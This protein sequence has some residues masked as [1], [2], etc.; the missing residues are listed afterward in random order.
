MLILL[1]TWRVPT[2][3][4]ARINRHYYHTFA[5]FRCS[6]CTQT[7]VFGSVSAG[8]QAISCGCRRGNPSHG[9]TVGGGSHSLLNIWR[10]MRQRC[11]SRSCEAYKWYG[12]RGITICRAWRWDFLR[13]FQWGITHGWQQ[14]LTIERVNNNGNY[15]PRNCRF[16]PRGRQARNRRSNKLNEALVLEAR[17][18][19]ASGERNSDL[20]R[21]FGITPTTMCKIVH[22]KIWKGVT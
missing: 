1:R 14:G 17:R 16:I 7:K 18:R 19:Y 13:F 10:G 8:R 2:R 6:F 21:A 12:R 3:Y 11:Y 4:V 22:N 20:A 15:S 5:E 9:M